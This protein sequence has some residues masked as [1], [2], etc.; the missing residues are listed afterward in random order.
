[1]SH[2]V[3]AVGL[4][5]G[6][7]RGGAVGVNDSVGVAVGDRALAVRAVA[8]VAVVAVAVVVGVAAKALVGPLETE[9]GVSG[10]VS[11]TLFTT[12]DTVGCDSGSVQKVAAALVIAEAADVL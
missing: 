5:V 7:E 12:S 1:M 3:A 9:V 6:A 10:A 2:S 11:C 4:A 8:L